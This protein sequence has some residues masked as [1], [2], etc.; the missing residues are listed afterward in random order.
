MYYFGLM[1]SMAGIYMLAGLGATLSLKTRQINLA[2]EGLI[3]AGGFV[4]AVFL[5]FFAKVNMPAFFAVSLAFLI[6]A[7][8][9]GLRMASGN[10][11]FTDVL[12]GAVIGTAVGF[13]VP[14]LHSKGF[15]SNFEKKSKSGQASVT[16]AGFSFSY[17]F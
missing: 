7:L 11:F 17:N 4:T 6:A 15:Y 16:P 12:V 1:L 9:G 3:Y 13:T 5:D 10:H 8:T 2:G 14:Y